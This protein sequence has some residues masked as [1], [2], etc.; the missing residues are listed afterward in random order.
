MAIALQFLIGFAAYAAPGVA[1]A[2]PSTTTSAERTKAAEVARARAGAP[3]A[4]G[5][6][7]PHRFDC[8]GLIDFAYRTAGHPLGVRTS[9]QMWNLGRRVSRGA[10][11]AGD[12]VFTWDRAKGHVGMYLGR[13]RYVHAPAPGR[14]VQVAVLPAAGG[15][16]YGAVRP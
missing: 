16:Y 6:A 3:Y 13:G 9:S 11:R 1:Q 8:S 15:G 10:L 14:R 4:L 2:A 12:L 7:G 5:A